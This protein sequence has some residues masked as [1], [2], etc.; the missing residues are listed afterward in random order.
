MKSV[1]SR[2]RTI[3]SPLNGVCSV[4]EGGS[5]Q[6]RFYGLHVVVWREH[7]FVHFRRGMGDMLEATISTG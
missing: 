5:M 3:V 1:E 4:F 6:A 2:S 7:D